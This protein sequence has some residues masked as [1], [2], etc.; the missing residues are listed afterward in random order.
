MAPWVS[1]A[2]VLPLLAAAAPVSDSSPTLT[3]GAP[4]DRWRIPAEVEPEVGSRGLSLPVIN[5]TAPDGS[6]KIRRGIIAGMRIAPNAS[7][8]IGLFETLPKDRRSHES[9]ARP[10]QVKQ[11]RSRKAAIGVTVSF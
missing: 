11:R 5:Y 8:G 1:A 3:P 6:L 7:L 9:P 2:F 10:M 4:D